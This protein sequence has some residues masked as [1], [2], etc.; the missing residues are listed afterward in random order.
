MDD[1]DLPSGKTPI[2]AGNILPFRPER[3]P[4]HR[5]ARSADGWDHGPSPEESLRVM[6]A[7]VAIKNKGLREKLTEILENA[8]RPRGQVPTPAKE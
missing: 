3:A 1:P 2:P 6:R 5:V 7:F 8:S 4:K